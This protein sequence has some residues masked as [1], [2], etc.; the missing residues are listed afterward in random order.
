MPLAGSFAFI[1]DILLDSVN[2]GKDVTVV[3]PG[4]FRSPS[5]GVPSSTP[6]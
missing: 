5:L 2:P 3:L 4:A 6:G 1:A